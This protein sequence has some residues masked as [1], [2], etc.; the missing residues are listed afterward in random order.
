VCWDWVD[1]KIHLAPSG[2]KQA[3]LKSNPDEIISGTFA[4]LCR[5]RLLKV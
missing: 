3:R 5:S 1:V 2:Q 4:E